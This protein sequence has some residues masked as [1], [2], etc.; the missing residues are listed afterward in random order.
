MIG[1]RWEALHKAENLTQ[2]QEILRRA[3]RANWII[4]SNM[5]SESWI[6]LQAY[7]QHTSRLTRLKCIRQPSIQ[8]GLHQSECF[9]G[10]V[11]N[12]FR[13]VAWPFARI[14]IFKFVCIKLNIWVVITRASKN[15]NHTGQ[16]SINW[17]WMQG[18]NWNGMEWCARRAQAF[19]LH[20]KLHI[21][22]GKS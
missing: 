14:W 13:H 17:S 4:R 19:C 7:I 2:T 8:L 11:C 5:S 1:Q 9:F 10:Q 3:G 15:V 22:E 12:G 20:P 16:M 18:C 6:K 21:L